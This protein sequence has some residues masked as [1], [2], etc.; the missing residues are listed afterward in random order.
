MKNNV[1]LYWNIVALNYVE[2]IYIF[3]FEEY[4]L[5]LTNKVAYSINTSFSKAD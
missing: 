5:T 1:R 4:Y 3:F 2:Y